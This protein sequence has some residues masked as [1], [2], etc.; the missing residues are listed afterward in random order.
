MSQAIV[1]KFLPATNRL[2]AR[3]KAS[4]QRG[5]L[6]VAFPQHLNEEAAHV[7]AARS[8]CEK[9]AEQDVAKYGTPTERNP[10]MRKRAFGWIP[11]GEGVHVF[12]E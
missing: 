3:V 5:S 8:L 6:T 10:W 7:F 4:C 1:T 11:S 12:S 9:F 2:G